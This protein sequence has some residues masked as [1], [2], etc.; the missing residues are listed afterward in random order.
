ME[1][2]E[3]G[4]IGTSTASLPSHEYAEARPVPSVIELEQYPAY[5]DGNELSVYQ[6]HVSFQPICKEE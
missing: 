3:T 6:H 4:V 5:V 1:D 2:D